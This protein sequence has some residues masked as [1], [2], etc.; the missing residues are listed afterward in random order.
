MD[1]HTNSS[2]HHPFHIPREQEPFP[3]AANILE[4]MDTFTEIRPGM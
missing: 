2:Q 4:N 1:Y 3:G